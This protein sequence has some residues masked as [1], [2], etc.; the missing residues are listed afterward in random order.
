MLDC[1]ERFANCVNFPD[2]RQPVCV[3]PAPRMQE[4]LR[5]LRGGALEANPRKPR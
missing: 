3:R 4:K 2:M 1:P 5:S